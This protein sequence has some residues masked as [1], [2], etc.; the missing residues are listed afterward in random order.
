[1]RNALR[2]VLNEIIA[3]TN[4]ALSDI[5]NRLRETNATINRLPGSEVRKL[6]VERK[7]QF[8]DNTYDLL[9]QRKAAAGIAIATTVSDWSIIERARLAKDLPVSPNT[10][11]IF[12]MALILGSGLPASVILVLDALNTKIKDKDDIEKITTIPILG[13][14]AKAKKYSMVSNEL[15]H[16]SLFAESLYTIRANLQYFSTDHSNS[17][18]GFTSSISGEGKSFCVVNLGFVLAKSNSRVLIIDADLRKS[19]LAK[20]FKIDRPMGLSDYLA[21]MKNIDDIINETHL[22]NL[23]VI[24]SG[25]FPPNP[26]DLLT[27]SNMDNLISELKNHYQ[28][29]LIDAPP[30]GLV[31]DYLLIQKYVNASI[32]LARCDLTTKRMIE[33]IDQLHENGRVNNLSILLNDVKLSGLYSG[34]YKNE[35]LKE[36]IENFKK[37]TSVVS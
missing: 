28:Y 22:P 5:S 27:N 16:R 8:S 37:E 2:E 14:I 35:Y 11:F 13:M 32:F 9:L 19:S 20:Y 12:L 1:M 29:I 6:G 34:K 36:E 15:N 24:L 26:F 18:F 17:I 7:F 3:S 4:L 21:G 33:N 10:K 31:S 25:S 23:D 30:L